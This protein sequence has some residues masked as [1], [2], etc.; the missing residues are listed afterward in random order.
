MGK[1]ILLRLVRMRYHPRYAGAQDVKKKEKRQEKQAHRGP[2][3]AIG[4]SIS[5]LVLISG[6]A[7]EFYKRFWVFRWT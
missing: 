7:T 2:K 4:E 1:C 6:L 5:E 3:L